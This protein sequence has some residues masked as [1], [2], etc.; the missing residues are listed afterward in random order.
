MSLVLCC[1]DGVDITSSGESDSSDKPKKLYVG[2]DE[3]EVIGAYG[4]CFPDTCVTTILKSTKEPFTGTGYSKFS[5]PRPLN[6]SIRDSLGRLSP[7]SRFIN[8]EED[9]FIN[10]KRVKISQFAEKGGQILVE[11]D[12]YGDVEVGQE[13]TWYDN[14]QLSSESIYGTISEL[15]S[16]G[17]K[18]AP[19]IKAIWYYPNGQIKNEIDGINNTH[20]E[21][22][23]NGNLI[24]HT[25]KN[26]QLRNKLGELDYE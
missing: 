4:D 25:D 8:Y 18:R 6:E 10:G 17:N 9:E 13:K 20:K 12:Y 1:G 7:P 16:P 5:K 14:G 23:E 21:Y 19:L 11:R 26:G 3:L 2:D 22:D 24:P 15:T